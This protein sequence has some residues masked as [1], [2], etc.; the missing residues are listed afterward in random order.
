MVNHTAADLKTPR[1][2]ASRRR[3]ITS[4]LQMSYLARQLARYGGVRTRRPFV[5]VPRS[6]HPDKQTVIDEIA[7][8][9]DDRNANP[10]KADWQFTT[11]RVT[12]KHLY[13]SI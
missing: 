7:A 6:A 2:S 10:A 3:S 1:E 5:P 9:E 11:A 12:L 8:W 4:Y 13:P